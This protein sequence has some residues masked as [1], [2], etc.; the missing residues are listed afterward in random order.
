[1]NP[2]SKS[3]LQDLCQFLEEKAVRLEPLLDDTIFPFEDSRAA[4][5]YLYA[6]KHMGKV[7][8]KI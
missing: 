6:A 4:F 5:E 8:I 1:M 2:G 7:V 3:D